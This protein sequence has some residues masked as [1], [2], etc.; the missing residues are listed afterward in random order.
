MLS[1]LY[2]DQAFA[3]SLR[4]S[5]LDS[6][7][8][9]VSDK[10]RGGWG[11]DRQ[12]WNTTDSQALVKAREIAKTDDTYIGTQAQKALDKLT[13]AAAECDRIERAMEPLQ[14]EFRR[15]G[16]WTRAFMVLNTGGHLHSSMECSTCF[17][18][19][20]FGW[21]PQASGLD[22][23]EIVEGAGSDA[24]TVCYPTAPV[25]ALKRE[26]ARWLYHSTEEDAIKA[27][28]ERAAEKADRL[29]KKIAK[30]LT[31]DGSE[32]TVVTERGTYGPEYYREHLRGQ[33]F[34]RK[35]HF[36]TEQAAT[37]WLVQQICYGYSARYAE[38]IATIKQAIVDKHSINLDEV[39]ANIEAKVIAK[40]RRDA[41]G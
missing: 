24:C 40:K 29:A 3:E 12:E 34:E 13:E 4:L 14:G 21:L 20:R 17:L 9:A 32:L 41:R 31:P 23:A 16:G 7:H 19:T 11:R 1:N 2:G 5:A 18:K 10:R 8:Y 15:R 30:A 38:A 37:K 27:R 26:R 25:D 6:L 22:E 33:D 28:E 39:E 36:K 35:E